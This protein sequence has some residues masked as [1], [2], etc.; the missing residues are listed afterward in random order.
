M[1]T[2]TTVPIFFGVALLTGILVPI[3]LV[4]LAVLADAAVVLWWGM[5]RGR[6][7]YTH[8]VEVHGAHR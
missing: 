2:L 1:H 7:A 8:Y 3:V 5:A 4:L 6:D